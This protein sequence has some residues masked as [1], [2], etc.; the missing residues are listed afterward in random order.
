MKK[1]LKG[2]L[3]TASNKTL[4]NHVPS[5]QYIPTC[6]IVTST[7]FNGYHRCLNTFWRSV[8]CV[9]I[10]NKQHFQQEDMFFFSDAADIKK[11]SSSCI[12]SSITINA[13]N[14]K[15]EERKRKR[16]LSQDQDLE[17]EVRMSSPKCI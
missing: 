10:N 1:P 2:L 8:V 17:G 11:R 7:I 4:L 6:I 3:C 9:L 15:R 5:V 16:N 13:I 12:A 14:I